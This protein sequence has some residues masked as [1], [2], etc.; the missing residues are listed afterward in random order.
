MNYCKGRKIKNFQIL[1]LIGKGS[2]ASVYK[3][4]R[5]SDKNIYAMKVM[6]GNELHKNKEK[7]G[8]L[9][10]INIL[11]KNSNPYLL[12]FYE[13]F[14]EKN[15]FHI[16]MEY[17]AKKDLKSFLSYRKSINRPL[18]EK[19]INHFIYQI[20]HGVKYLHDHNVIHR[21]LK[22]ANIM[23]DSNLNLKI[24]DFGISKIFTD[25]NKFAVTQ[26]GSPL[27]M[28]PEALGEGKYY[29]KTDIWA[30]GCIL[31][32]I[33]TLDY[34]FNANSLPLLYKI[35]KCANFNKN[36]IRNNNYLKLINKM[37]CVDQYSRYDINTIIDILPKTNDV[38]KDD[39][40]FKKTVNILKPAIIIPRNQ[41]Q[42]YQLLPKPSYS[43]ISKNY[44]LPEINPN[45]N[46]DKKIYNEKNNLI[47]SKSV[48]DNKDDHDR[49]MKMNNYFYQNNKLPP[50][51]NYNKLKHIN[52]NNNLP[53][54]CDDNKLKP[55]KN[56]NKL[57]PIKDYNRLRPTKYNDRYNSYNNYKSKNVINNIYN[58][59]NDKKQY[60]PIPQFES[61]LPKI[62]Y[63]NDRYN[64]KHKEDN[65]RIKEREEYEKKEYE[66]R[67]YE[68][69]LNNYKGY[70]QNYVSPYNQY[71][72]NKNINKIYKKF[73]NNHYVSEYKDKY[74]Y[75]PKI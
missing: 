64:L 20:C 36:K 35:I 56:Y 26:I 60:F 31:Y 2:Y 1:K 41:N 62:I 5:I 48:N 37:L 30:I 63:H 54:T 44:S 25:Q 38:Y 7:L 21:D 59:N 50:A 16:I 40:K 72:L 17:A 74:K 12:K 47:R 71:V 14:I 65:K 57:Q 58:S 27:Y 66:K 43:P 32:E 19:T 6:N 52:N 13:V 46:E 61:K 11:S 22:P 73:N 10:E 51:N 39:N 53:P 8:L 24:G 33:I 34:A 23:V 67:E 15:N 4:E 9:N 45:E 49:I 42:W 68:K 18:S 69:K 55:V 75:L 28:S 70:G 3:V 29:H